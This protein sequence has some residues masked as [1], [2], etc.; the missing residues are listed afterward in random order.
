[1]VIALGIFGVEPLELLR[2][3][4][5]EQP[6]LPIFL[7]GDRD[8]ALPDE[9]AAARVGASR[10]FLRPIDADALADAIEK[11]A[12]EVEV[13]QDVAEAMREFDVRPPTIDA[14]PLVE[15]S[16]VEME[17]D[18][19]DDE[20]EPPA[21]ALAR[22]A[23]KRV[24]TEV[25]KG[26]IEVPASAPHHEVALNKVEANLEMDAD[27]PTPAP[28]RVPSRIELAPPI[29]APPLTVAIEPLM[30]AD[31]ALTDAG[32]QQLVVA[33]DFVV[34]HAADEA[35]PPARIPEAL[36]RGEPAERAR[37]AFDERSTF[38]RR[39]E[40]ELSAA[41]R[42]LFPDSPSTVNARRDEYEDAL[43]D[44]D[45]DAV[46]ID[47]IPGI[48]NDWADPL[49]ARFELTPHRA[50]ATVTRPRRGSLR[51]RTRGRRTAA[52]PPPTRRRCPTTRAISST[53]DVATLFATL[54]AA[55]FTGAVTLLR[56]D[57]DK[58]LYLRRRHAGGRALDVRARSPA[59]P[60]VA[61]G[62]H[63]PGP[64]RPRA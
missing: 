39:L 3:V 14:A 9:D 20:E 7:L 6:K 23:L 57:G 40:N 10:L 62:R 46:G 26:V 58:T 37:P 45:L 55:G 51:T 27:D 32:L 19:G 28:Q 8:G 1:M 42:R 38:A 60:A 16:I 36:K 24:P 44:I 4:R 54:H 53:T 22:I 35:P 29:E 61:R 52:A 31:D 50:T 18:Y 63:Q 12:V 41:E 64:A 59:R 33:P 5:A 47:T 43:G 34:K 56:G 21:Q 15:E 2:A 13:G 17:A 30:R 11:R 49:D 48:S 25:M